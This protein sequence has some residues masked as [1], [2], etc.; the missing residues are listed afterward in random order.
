MRCVLLALL[1][2][3]GCNREAISLDSDGGGGMVD[4]STLTNSDGSGGLPDLSG[5]TP[6]D[7]CPESYPNVP[8]LGALRQ[9][10]AGSWYGTHSWAGGPPDMVIAAFTPDFHYSAHCTG[11]C[12]AFNYGIDDDDPG[13]TYT[14]D[15]IISNG[16]GEGTIQIMFFPGQDF[17]TGSLKSIRT[18]ADGARLDFDFWPDWLGPHIGPLT[19]RLTRMMN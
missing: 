12:T 18:C 6:G 17:T 4:G 7:P 16:D 19:F 9:Q 14:L 2:V 1:A 15:N 5:F 3:A 11:M 13:K 8:T 10:F